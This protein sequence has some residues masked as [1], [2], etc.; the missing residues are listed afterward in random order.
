IGRPQLRGEPVTLQGRAQG[1]GGHLSFTLQA[2]AGKLSAGPSFGLAA[3]TLS[4][5]GS[6]AERLRVDGS[7]TADDLLAGGQHVARLATP[8]SY[9]APR[10]ALAKGVLAV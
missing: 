4:L 2:R 10:A 5:K 7:L 3:A 1:T 9:Q 6:L 8:F